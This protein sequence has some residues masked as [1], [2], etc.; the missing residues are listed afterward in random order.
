MGKGAV[1]AIQ[2]SL[3]KD[4]DDDMILAIHLVTMVNGISYARLSLA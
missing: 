1:G 4:Q 2:M 3:R